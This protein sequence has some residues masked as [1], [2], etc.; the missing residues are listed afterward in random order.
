VPGAAVNL[1]EARK[2]AE[3]VKPGAAWTPPG[4]IEA[5]GLCAGALLVVEN[6]CRSA[7]PT[8]PAWFLRDKILL[9]IGVELS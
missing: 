5:A 2:L 3:S 6:D 4:L 7:S 8:W 9:G 1:A